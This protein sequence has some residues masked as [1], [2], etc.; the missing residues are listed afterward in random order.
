MGMEARRCSEAGACSR[1]RS[2]CPKGWFG[3]GS[4][5]PCWVS[6]YQGGVSLARDGSVKNGRT[7]NMEGNVQQCTRGIEMSGVHRTRRKF[8]I[9][10]QLAMVSRG[11]GHRGAA[12]RK[13]GGVAVSWTRG[14]VGKSWPRE[15]HRHRHFLAILG[16][17]S[18]HD[19]SGH[20]RP[21][22]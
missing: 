20:R 8:G 7:S 1:A 11:S 2:G 17:G 10:I 14:V 5:Q 3:C 15:R 9:Q 6:R 13:A 16:D 22:F 21:T 12:C 4:Q 19:G 18:F